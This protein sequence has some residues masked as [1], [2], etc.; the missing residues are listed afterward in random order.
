MAHAPEDRYDLQRFVAAQERTYPHVLAEIRQGR[1]RTHWMWFIFPQMAGLGSSAT[2][3]LYA[4]ET[5]AEAAAYLAHPILGARL[6]E[7]AGA[8]LSLASASA[9]DIFGFPDDLKLR[10]SMTLFASVSPPGSIFQQVLDRY[11]GG[12]GDQ[13]TLRLLGGTGRP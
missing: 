4:I 6:R 7:C 3:A 5:R 12:E 11:F 8:L 10:S 2:A 13:R 9:S 1:K